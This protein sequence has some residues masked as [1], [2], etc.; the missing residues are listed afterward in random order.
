[1]YYDIFVRNALGNYRD[2]LREV[3]YSPTMAYY[4]TF[5]QSASYA[6][7]KDKYGSD[8]WPDENYA[9]EVMQIFTMGLYQLHNNGTTKKDSAGASLAT[10]DNDDIA[11]FARA[12]SACDVAH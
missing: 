9:R 7:N 3:S 2:V 5:L 10:Y 4:L 1:V 11:N 12:V 8:I 6:Y